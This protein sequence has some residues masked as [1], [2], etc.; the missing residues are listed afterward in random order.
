MSAATGLLPDAAVAA[1]SSASDMT[2]PARPT[3]PASTD[4]PKKAAHPPFPLF[5]SAFKPESVTCMKP[6]AYP[7]QK[8][9]FLSFKNAP[10]YPLQPSWTLGAERVP[11]YGEAE[12]GVT[13]VLLERRRSPLRVAFVPKPNVENKKLNV[14]AATKLSVTFNMPAADAA[15]LRTALD[16]LTALVHARRAQ[17]FPGAHRVM[18]ATAESNVRAYIAMNKDAQ[19]AAFCEPPPEALAHMIEVASARLTHDALNKSSP[20]KKGKERLPAKGEP[21]PPPGTP[22][23]FWDDSIRVMI[24]GYG[25]TVD[26]KRTTLNSAGYVDKIA[27]FP[28]LLLPGGRT[29][30]PIPSGAGVSEPTTFVFGVGY[31]DKDNLIYLPNTPH[32]TPDMRVGLRVPG[33]YDLTT[34]GTEAEVSFKIMLHLKSG[35]GEDDTDKPLEGSWVLNATQIVVWKSAPKAARALPTRFLLAPSAEAAV[36]MATTLV[37]DPRVPSHTVHG[38]SGEPISVPHQEAEEGAYGGGDG[39]EDEEGGGGGGGGA[40]DE[41]A[42]AEM[43]AAAAAIESGFSAT[44]APLAKKART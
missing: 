26:K 23:T 17:L 31:D 24:A 19:G 38:I 2:T 13:R 10:G 6:S 30:P 12:D 9:F 35:A 5:I 36:A 1:A 22:K 40:E 39:N 25:N 18:L 21:A 16:Q 32:T 33:P 29:S 8:G 27:F 7:G 44:S 14:T 15:H 34:L 43:M 4:A 42:E 41:E 3:A 20:L 11:V 37:S 28:T